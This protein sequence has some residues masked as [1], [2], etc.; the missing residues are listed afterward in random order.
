MLGSISAFS[1]SLRS[2]SQKITDP[3]ALAKTLLLQSP[4]LDR[5][6]GLRKSF[7]F[8]NSICTVQYPSNNVSLWV[9]MT[10]HICVCGCLPDYQWL[11]SQI[12]FLSWTFEGV[13]PWH[14]IGQPEGSA[15]GHSCGSCLKWVTRMA[16]SHRLPK[17][18]ITSGASQTW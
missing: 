9:C 16:M 4:I 15:E 8:L 5:Y 2:P 12:S 1:P 18:E 11:W 17:A 6:L 14:S 3:Q 10:E 13:R 7:Y